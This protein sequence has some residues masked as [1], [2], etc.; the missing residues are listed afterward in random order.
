[1]GDDELNVTDIHTDRHT[2]SAFLSPVLAELD[3]PL[4]GQVA[5]LDGTQL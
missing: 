4:A 5:N 3:K 2:V 1:M